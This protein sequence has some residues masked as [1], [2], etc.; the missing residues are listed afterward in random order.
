MHIHMY[1]DI[2]FEDVEIEVYRQADIHDNEVADTCCLLYF[3]Q[4]FWA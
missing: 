2:C 1:L 3:R 4:K